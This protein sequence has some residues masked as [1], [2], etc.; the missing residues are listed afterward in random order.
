ML[1]HCNTADITCSQGASPTCC[2]GGEVNQAAME[3]G[4]C[5]SAK[6]VV[7]YSSPIIR[8]QAH[9]LCELTSKECFPSLVPHACCVMA[10]YGL[11]IDR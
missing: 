3:A 4:H 10:V 7:L 6:G 8:Q 11:V 1:M 2:A 5:R 9:T